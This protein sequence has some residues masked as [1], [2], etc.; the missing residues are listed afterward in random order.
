VGDSRRAVQL[1]LGY[2]QRS[3][4]VLRGLA[5]TRMLCKQR[6]PH[7]CVVD[8]HVWKLADN[9]GVT[10]MPGIARPLAW[11]GNVSVG[12]PVPRL[13]IRQALAIME[14]HH[15]VAW[16]AAL[17]LRAALEVA[18]PPGRSRSSQPGGSSG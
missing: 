18:D 16:E 13:N 11:V 10:I 5:P 6:G 3:R 8:P 17:H 12:R 14:R 4:R 1:P 7:L 2:R 9:T 15:V